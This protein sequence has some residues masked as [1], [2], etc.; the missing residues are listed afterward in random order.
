MHA[1]YAKTNFDTYIRVM[2]VIVVEAPLKIPLI[3]PSKQ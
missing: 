2:R 3:F 1:V